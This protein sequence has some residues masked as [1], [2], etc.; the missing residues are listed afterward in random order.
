M[1]DYFEVASAHL[2]GV[3]DDLRA[4]YR[5]REKRQSHPRRYALDGQRATM[6]SGLSHQQIGRA[7]V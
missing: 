3:L 6:V 2:A 1:T 7:H 4:A 5:G